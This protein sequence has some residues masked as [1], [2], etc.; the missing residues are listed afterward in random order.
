MLIDTMRDAEAV[1]EQMLREGVII[2]A[3]TAY[4]LPTYLRITIGTF[5]ENQRFLGAFSRVLSRLPVNGG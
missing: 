2:R 3:M 5:E 1:Y 4:G